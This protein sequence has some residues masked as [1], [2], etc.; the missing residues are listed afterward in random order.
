MKPYSKRPLR[1]R[2]NLDIAA[3]ERELDRL[4]DSVSWDADIRT[5]QLIRDKESL[6]RQ[7]QHYDKEV[8]AGYRHPTTHR[9]GADGQS[10]NPF[11]DISS[12]LGET[13]NLDD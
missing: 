6:L 2:I 3:I 7:A 12:S 10:K 4:Q 1:E 8:A 13:I 11:P 5:A 9:W